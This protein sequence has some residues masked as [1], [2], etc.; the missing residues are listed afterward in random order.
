M[1]PA[2][3]PRGNTAI[4]KYILQ[5]QEAVRPALNTHRTTVEAVARS[6]YTTPEAPGTERHAVAQ[7]TAPLH[8]RGFVVEQGIAGF[9]NAFKATYEHLDPEQMRKGLRHAHVLIVAEYHADDLS[10]HTHARHLVAAGA[11]ALALALADVADYTFGYITVI[12][13]PGTATGSSIVALANA[14]V[15]DGAD[16]VFGVRPAPA[17]EGAFF[18]T[19]S[20]GNTLAGVDGDLFFVPASTDALV[21]L[22]TILADHSTTLEQLDRI[23]LDHTPAGLHLALRA[24]HLSRVEE[25]RDW[26]TA[27]ATLIAAEHD[28]SLEARWLPAI[29]EMLVSRVL[30]RRAKTYAVMAGLR[31]DPP[32]KAP[33]GEPTPW[34]AIAYRVPAADCWFPIGDTQVAFG[35]QEFGQAATTPEAFDQMFFAVTGIALAALDLLADINF[36][37]IADNML[38]RSLSERG[39]QRE[40]RRWTGVHSVI[41]RQSSN[42]AVKADH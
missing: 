36:R 4:P 14:G 19:D 31:S 12:G 39:I 5:A 32:R 29:P 9:P 3:G 24:A 41:P 10:G 27:R 13:C 11:L 21:A 20:S 25:L 35:T 33:P 6:I 23:D 30:V 2:D 26:A 42:G 1:L 16:A 8:G 40:H 15:F 38:V 28:V 18:T 34:G 17:G 37:A 7:L 22:Q